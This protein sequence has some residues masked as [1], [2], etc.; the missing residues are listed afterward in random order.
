VLRILLVVGDLRDGEEVIHH[1][2]S[3]VVGVAVTRTIWW[4]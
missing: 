3:K 2:G 1:L 4:M